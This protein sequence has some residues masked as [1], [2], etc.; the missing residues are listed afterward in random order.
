M[1]TVKNL[2][3]DEAIEKIKELANRKICLFCTHDNGEITSRPMDTQG[4]DDDGSMWFFSRR[5]SHKNDQ[6]SQDNKVYLMYMDTGKQ[7][8]LSLSGTAEIVN[9]R[10]KVEELWDPMVKAWF[11]GGKDDPEL[12]LIRVNPED[13]HYWDTKNGKLVSL[14]KVAVAAITGNQD[15]DGSLEGSLKV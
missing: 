5:S 9:D 6:I 4:I 10:A 1:G 12:T 8:Y 14:I 3:N 13:G 15:K 2:L 11:E 7:H